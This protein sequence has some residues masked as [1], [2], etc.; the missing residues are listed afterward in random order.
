[1]K[2]TLREATK[3][4]KELDSIRDER[5]PARLSFAISNNLEN[6]GKEYNRVEKERENLC[7]KYAEKG[8][9]GKVLTEEH[10][11]NNKK[12][13]KY[14]MTEESEKTLNEE[15]EDLMGMEVDIEICRV[16]SDVFEQCEKNERYSIPTVKEIRILGFMTE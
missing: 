1:M 8:E 4:Y 6:L 14:K 13:T 10:I 12:C 11:I 16:K 3:R 2:M 15:Y 7:R 5:F 9:D